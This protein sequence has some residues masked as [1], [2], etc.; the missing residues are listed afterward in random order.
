VD[1]LVN[2][3]TNAYCIDILYSF[4]FYCTLQLL[5]KMLFAASKILTQNPVTALLQRRHLDMSLEHT[6]NQTISTLAPQQP[7]V[8]LS[9]LPDILPGQLQTV[10]QHGAILQLPPRPMF[11]DVTI[12]TSTIS[13]NWKVQDQSVDISS[14]RTLTFSLHCYADIP[15]KSRSKLTL[16]S[17]LAK[18][19]TP[20]SGFEEMSELSSESNNTFSSV[21]PSAM[22][23]R[24]ISLLGQPSLPGVNKDG[25]IKE[26]LEESLPLKEDMKL[27]ALVLHPPPSKNIASLIPEAIRLPKK[28]EDLADRPVVGLGSNGP[29]LE[30]IGKPPLTTQG[31]NRGGILNLPPL[32]MDK[33]AHL[34]SLRSV[35]TNTTSGVL[36]D[37]EDENPN[38]NPRH[39]NRKMIPQ[40]SSHSDSHSTSSSSLSITSTGSGFTEYMDLGRYCEGFIF[41]EIYCGEDVSYLYSGAVSGASYYFRVRCHNAAGWG[42]WSDTVQC[43]TRQ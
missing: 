38:I 42:P 18:T 4:I 11:S 14:D 6:L 28:K 36:A 22:G 20:E 32:L 26:E 27:P 10:R 3:F 17:G 13:L 34:G 19:S 9:L 21:P 1:I 24:N 15:R 2:I 12:A 40:K 23:S 33:S 35:N 25:V 7:D 41:E 31:T 39:K 29:R 16:S 5:F 8:P 37:G 43:V 30:P